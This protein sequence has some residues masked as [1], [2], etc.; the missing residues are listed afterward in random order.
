[1][2]ASPAAGRHGAHDSFFQEMLQ[3]IVMMPLVSMNVK[4][5]AG[6]GNHAGHL[7]CGL[8]TEGSA[9][10]KTCWSQ[11]VGAVCEES[12]SAGTL[13]GKRAKRL[14]SKPSSMCWCWLLTPCARKQGT[15]FIAQGEKRQ[16][17]TRNGPTPRGLEGEQ[18]GNLGKPCGAAGLLRLYPPHEFSIFKWCPEGTASEPLSP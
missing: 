11:F 16:K 10:N 8:P 4:R 5:H 15:G 14:L 6:G 13:G 7:V 18:A 2:A 1:M 17:T 9:T 3:T 12:P